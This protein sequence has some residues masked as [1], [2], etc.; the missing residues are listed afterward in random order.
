MYG[1]VAVHSTLCEFES[2]VRHNFTINYMQS[3]AKDIYNTVDTQQDLDK[4]YNEAMEY[5]EKLMVN[6]TKLMGDT[7][8]GRS[9]E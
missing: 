6:F 8:F 7:K 1:I 9:I 5:N 3:I 4:K 2:G